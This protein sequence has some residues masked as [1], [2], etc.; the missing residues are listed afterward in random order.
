MGDAFDRLINGVIGREG[1]Y[2]NHPDDRGGE[3]MWGVTIAVARRYGY[4][5]RMRDM[6]RSEAVRIYRARYWSEPGYDRIALMSVPVADELFAPKRN[7]G[8]LPAKGEG[9]GTPRGRQAH[10]RTGSNGGRWS[11][12]A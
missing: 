6:P 2:A 9:L 5:G 12:R 8:P 7:E 1:G 10:R 4:V 11:S 3:T